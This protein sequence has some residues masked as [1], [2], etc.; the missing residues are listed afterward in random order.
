MTAA[1]SNI[2]GRTNRVHTFLKALD[3]FILPS[4]G[5]GISNALLEAMSSGLPAFCFPVGDN[6]LIIQDGKNGFICADFEEMMKKLEYF[7]AHPLIKNEIAKEARRTTLKIFNWERSSRN[8]GKAIIL[9]GK[10]KR[11]HKK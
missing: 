4:Q 10:Q 2:T 5:E 3:A 9:V 6:P 8:L 7:I 11:P 1:T